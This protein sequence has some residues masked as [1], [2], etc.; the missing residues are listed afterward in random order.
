MK[1]SVRGTPA[2]TDLD[3]NGDVEVIAVGYD[4]TVYVWDFATPYDD[5]RMPWPMFRANVHR[6][7]RYGFDTTTPVTEVAPPAR[8]LLGQNYPNPFNPTTTIVFE[9]PSAGPASLVVYDV[10]GARVRTLVDGAVRAGRHDVVW[11]GR[12]DS[13]Q[14]VGS[15]VYFYRIATTGKSLTKKMVLLK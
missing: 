6:N 13:H 14:P 1:D 8:L 3:R 4:K 10:T 2:I 5:S 7:G 12:N 9:V 11:D 15:G